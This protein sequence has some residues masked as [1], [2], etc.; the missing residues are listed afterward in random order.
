M[1]DQVLKVTAILLLVM[2]TIAGCIAYYVEMRVAE[3]EAYFYYQLGQKVHEGK[4]DA[5]CWQERV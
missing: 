5:F 2:L 3:Q 4:S 1:L